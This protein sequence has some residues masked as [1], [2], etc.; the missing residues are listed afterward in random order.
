MKTWFWATK[1]HVWAEEMDQWVKHFSCMPEDHSLDPR[2][3][4]G[5]LPITLRYRR[6]R[7]G[8]LV[9]S[10]LLTLAKLLSSGFKWRNWPRRTLNINIWIPH[11]WT[12]THM[13]IHTHL[14]MHRHMHS[15]HIANKQKHDKQVM[16]AY[17]CSQS[18]GEIRD[19]PITMADGQ[20][21]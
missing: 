16:L 1:Y 21:A 6:Q 3:L 15:I 7:Q 8:T 18:P 14:N 20:W 13:C 17:V 2:V 4:F 12:Y 9:A 11:G 5:D 19:R 10:C